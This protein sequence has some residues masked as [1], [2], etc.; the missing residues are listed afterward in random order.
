MCDFIRKYY[1][2]AEKPWPKRLFY[3]CTKMFLWYKPQQMSNH[4]DLNQFFQRN[5]N[6]KAEMI[7]TTY[8]ESY[9]KHNKAKIISIRLYFFFFLPYQVLQYLQLNKYASIGWNKL[10][11]IFVA[12]KIFGMKKSKVALKHCF[13]QIIGI[14]HIVP[15]VHG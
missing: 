2:A 5:E 14:Q 6:C 7:I 12:I 10:T 3:S 13:K 4:H 11:V 15:L 8:C 1:S 9:H